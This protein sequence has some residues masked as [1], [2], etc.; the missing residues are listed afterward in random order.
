MIARDWGNIGLPQTAAMKMM[1]VTKRE[2]RAPQNPHIG[3][4]SLVKP[5]ETNGS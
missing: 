1:G 3:H 4:V 2:N 5:C